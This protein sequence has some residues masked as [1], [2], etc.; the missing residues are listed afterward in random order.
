MDGTAFEQRF[1]TYR[2]YSTAIRQTLEAAGVELCVF[3]PDLARTGLESSENVALIERLLL[4]TSEARLR[5]VVHDTTHLE[6]A[7]PAA[8]AS[9]GKFFALL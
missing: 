5:I 4:A 3:D 7:Q 1:D 2:E 6:I 8:V 9:D